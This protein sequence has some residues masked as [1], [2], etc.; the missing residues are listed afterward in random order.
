[1]REQRM[2]APF[3]R[4][5]KS[6][7]VIEAVKIRDTMNTLKSVS[8]T[9]PFSLAGE[10]FTEEVLYRKVNDEARVV[11]KNAVVDVHNSG[12][13]ICNCELVIFGETDIDDITH[14]N[15]LLI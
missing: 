14:C 8:R 15:N 9:F 5:L 4:R 2:V 10:S 13:R 1:M 11:K 3:V 6:D 12:I 7:L